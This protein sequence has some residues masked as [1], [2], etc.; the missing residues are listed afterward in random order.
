VSVRI[1]LGMA[2]FPF[3]G[4]R[5][6]LH[7]LDQA[8]DSDIDSVWVSERLISTQLQ[9]EPIAAFGV[10]A[11]RTRRLKFG[12]NAIIAPLRDPLVL[13]KQCA[14]LD[15]LSEGRL[16]PA[17]GVGGE[18]APEFTA[19][20]RPVAGRGR[21]GD[22]VLEICALLWQGA[23]VTYRG[24]HFRYV[25]AVIAPAPVQQPLPLWIGGSS[26]AAIRR[27]A[28]IGTGWLGGTQAPGE[29]ARVVAGI[30]AEVATNGRTI[31]DDH[32]GAGFPFRFGSPSEPI[33]ERAMAAYRSLGIADPA[34]VV[35]VGDA[36]SIVARCNDY[37]AAGASKF[38]L[39]PLGTDDADIAAQ[40]QRLIDEVLPRVHT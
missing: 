24:K 5:A 11:G 38:V 7:W 26:E 6:F 23:P 10:I 18:R 30:K 21:L 40:T 37:I 36:D 39:R 19:T 31:D 20:G 22:E 9:M 13:A 33:V 3:S 32:Y 16:L 4:P 12:M 2:G 25:D 15:F 34:A 8:E 1:G 29:V 35:A 27:T 28:R 17:F 14:T